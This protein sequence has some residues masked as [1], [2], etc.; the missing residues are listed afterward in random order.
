MLD[1]RYI[2][3]LRFSE[4]LIDSFIAGAQLTYT[5]MCVADYYLR[6]LKDDTQKLKRYVFDFEP[7][8]DAP[9]IMQL[10]STKPENIIE[11]ANLPM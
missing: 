1:I 7:V 3:F 10:T 11:L 8:Q 9:L 2:I 6:K 5:E 4:L